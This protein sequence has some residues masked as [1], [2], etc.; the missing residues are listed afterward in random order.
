MGERRQTDIPDLVSQ[1][2]KPISTPHDVAEAKRLEARRR[3]LVGGASAL[4]LIVTIG[5]SRRA[6]AASE[7]VCA[8]LLA[9]GAD[10]EFE[11]EP[12]PGASFICELERDD[13]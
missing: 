10:L 8:S 1:S 7:N 4:P 12:L 5:W 13:D 6:F 11:D 3:Y 9:Q 2:Q